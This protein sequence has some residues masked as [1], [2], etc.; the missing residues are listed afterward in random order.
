MST[1]RN[2]SSLSGKRVLIVGDSMLDLFSDYS[3]NRF[4]PEGPIPVAELN[5]QRVHAGGASNVAINTRA[6]GCQTTLIVAVGDD[7][8]GAQL[9]E[10][11]SDAG[12]ET[13]QVHTESPT[14]TKHRIGS[15]GHQFLRIDRDSRITESDGERY[16]SEVFRQL[17]D[18]DFDLLVVSD[19][20]K[21]ALLSRTI[22]EAISICNLRGIRTIVD[23]KGKDVSV[24]HGA[25]VLKPNQHEADLLLSSL[26]RS[27]LDQNSVVSVQSKLEVLASVGNVDF[28]VGTRG[29]AGAD[30]YNRCEQK[31]THL[32][33]PPI[34]IANVA[35][36]GDTFLA[37]LA[38]LMIAD[39]PV[40]QAAEVAVLCASY[41]C[42][43][44]TTAFPPLSFVIS[45]FLESEKLSSSNPV[46]SKAVALWIAN[47]FQSEGSKVVFTNGCFDLLHAG[48]VSSL[49]FAKAQGDFLIVA[50]NSDSSV[51]ELKGG[52]R[53][54]I[55]SGDRAYMLR[56]LSSVDLVVEFDDEDPSDLIELLQPNVLV[57]GDDYE[58]NQ[59]AGAQFV[60]DSGGTVEIF[61]LVPGL[62]TSS[63]VDQIKSSA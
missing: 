43:F 13:I 25:T 2:L 40:L 24:Y 34:S 10:I 45:K 62:S 12:V 17:N 50:I 26:D 27:V 57:K 33:A 1:W 15:S 5:H 54:Y 47:S 22:T 4:S 52:S 56:A 36:A 20:S 14:T 30:V 6:L 9:L 41:V 63:L 8:E 39:V 42:E 38:C 32:D 16:Q 49:N 59:I 19:Y 44:P 23:P 21:G 28:V 35:G 3:V 53:P 48:H 11:L 37:T 61:P 60:L 31:F 51:Q 58:L 46:E 18:L 55:S 7:G 29:A